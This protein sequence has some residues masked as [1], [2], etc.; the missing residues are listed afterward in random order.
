MAYAPTHEQLPSGKVIIRHFGA[1]GL[2]SAEIHAYGHMDIAMTCEFSAGVKV[3]EMYFS[4][5]RLVSRSSYEKARTAYTD[6]SLA[7]NAIEDSSADLLRMAG[8][9]RRQRA[10]QTKE[11]L[12][13]PETARANDSFCRTLME[14]GKR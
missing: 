8:R 4:K 13:N 11:H 3:G 14:N 10:A 9:E 6:M 12:P 1:D 2:L 5:R 7:D